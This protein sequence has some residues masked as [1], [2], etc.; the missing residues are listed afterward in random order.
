MISVRNSLKYNDISRLK[1]N[2]NVD[3]TFICNSQKIETNK[4]ILQ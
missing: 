1:I 2:V 4:N 3:R